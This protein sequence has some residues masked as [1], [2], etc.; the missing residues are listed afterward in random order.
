MKRRTP[1]LDHVHIL[2]IIEEGNMV[3]GA[4]ACQVEEGKF[5]VGIKS[6]HEPSDARMQIH[7]W[8]M[9]AVAEEHEWSHN[10]N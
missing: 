4:V 9:G 8:L 6:H 2:Q 7:D 5:K 10:K 3:T 1:N